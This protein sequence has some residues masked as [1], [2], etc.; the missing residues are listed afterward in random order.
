MSLLNFLILLVVAAVCGSVGMSIAGFSRGGCLASLVVGFVGAYL[1]T[2]LAGQLGLPTMLVLDIGGQPFP[3]IWAVI[4][5]II[6]AAVL[7]L[8]FRQRR[9]YY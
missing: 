3:L 9:V 2:W 7:G 5:S 1:G 4:G 6:F 8:L